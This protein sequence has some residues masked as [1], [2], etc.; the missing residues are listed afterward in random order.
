MQVQI[1]NQKQVLNKD[2]KYNITHGAS[3]TEL[4]KKKNA[5]GRTWKP[6]SSHH[7]TDSYPPPKPLVL[8]PITNC[9]PGPGVAENS[10]P[11]IQVTRQTQDLFWEPA[12]F[13]LSL[14]KHYKWLQF[15]R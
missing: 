10:P 11:A 1:C 9:I 5:A 15:Y 4:K 14:Y 12:S 8:Q 13:Q 6:R 7:P 3:L 2:G